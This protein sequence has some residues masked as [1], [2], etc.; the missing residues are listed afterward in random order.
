[1]QNN[2]IKSVKKIITTSSVAVVALYSGLAVSATMSGEK[3]K[4]Y[5]PEE[6][7]WV[8]S[9]SCDSNSDER[10]VQR[11]TDGTQ[12]C[13]DQ[14]SSYCADTKESAADLVCGQE[15]TSLFENE[16]QKQAQAEAEEQKKR[17]EARARAQREAQQ[18][19]AL[20]KQRREA[21]ETQ[22]RAQETQRQQQLLLDEQ[23]LEIEQQKISLRRQELELQRRSVEIRE[24][25]KE[26]EAEQ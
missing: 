8:V 11:K 20:A 9:V 3:F 21:A 25:L 2:V 4:E 6:A 1:M 23:L 16:S 15:V 26:L 24:T 13:N 18:Q 7:Y 22:K 10:I 5:A 19:Q 14:F 17:E 12:W